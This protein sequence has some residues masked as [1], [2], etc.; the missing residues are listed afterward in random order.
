MNSDLCDENK[1]EAQTAASSWIN[2]GTQVK[3]TEHWLE[4]II[5]K[6]CLM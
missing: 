3:E 1:H 5:K 4:C 6:N 2:V